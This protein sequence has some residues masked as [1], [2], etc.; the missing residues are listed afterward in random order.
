MNPPPLDLSLPYITEGLEG[1]GG[2]IRAR[3]EDFFVEEVPLYEPSGHGSHLYVNITKRN[4]TTREVQ[5]QL[6]GLFKL[7]PRNIGT[8]G[9]K[10]KHAVTTQTFSVLFEGNDVGSGEAVERIEDRLGVRV[11]WA[12]FHGNKI[13]AGHLIGNRFV[14]MV[15]G[16]RMP[17]GKAVERAKRIA[18]VIHRKGMPN[19]YGQQ[20]MG[21]NGGNVREGWDI[22]QGR[23][24]PRDRWLGKLMVAAYQSY[25]CNRYLAERVRRGLFGKSLLGDIAKKHET[26]GI[27]W[28]NDPEAEQLRF[29]AQEISFTAPIFGFKMSW[30]LG[31]PGAI[32][33]EIL[34]ESGVSMET[35]RRAKLT[36]TRRFG[37]LVPRI[38]VEEMSRGVRLSF[39]LHKGG[40]ATSL[41]REFMKTV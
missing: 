41:L 27:F 9:L 18:E 15:S 5:K 6:A 28:V 24:R 35:F 8:A 29:D 39:M 17:I 37:R 25:L 21:R 36:G 4:Q 10:D 31:V 33:E 12:K 20:R 30:P 14:I 7:R 19:Y 1:I 40:Y 26:G 38:E 2:L 22:L 34:V 32:E 13:R 3:P 16:L 11:N 23:R